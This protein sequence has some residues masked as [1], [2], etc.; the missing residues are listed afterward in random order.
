M[1]SS[2]SPQTQSLAYEMAQV[3]AS[4]SL[5]SS[6]KI[7]RLSYNGLSETEK[8]SLRQKYS[9]ALE[10]YNLDDLDLYE[11]IEGLEE[12]EEEEYLD[13]SL[14]AGDE[15]DEVSSYRKD[16]SSKEEISYFADKYAEI[17][18]EIASQV[19]P[20]SF[21]LSGY[22]KYNFNKISSAYAPNATY[23]QSNVKVYA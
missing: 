22:N 15:S 2:I 12:E 3:S 19:T 20:V 11:E 6:S 16:V 18:D 17:S 13:L 9:A 7:E 4:S 8:E 1:V 10:E 21:N 14:D 5:A 23:V